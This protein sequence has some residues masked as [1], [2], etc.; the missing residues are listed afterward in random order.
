MP[1]RRRKKNPLTETLERLVYVIKRGPAYEIGDQN[2]TRQDYD[3]VQRKVPTAVDPVS[4]AKWFED[5][6]RDVRHMP[7][8]GI[9]YDEAYPKYPGDVGREVFTR[10]KRWIDIASLLVQAAKVLVVRTEDNEFTEKER[11]QL[12]KLGLVD[13]QIHELELGTLFSVSEIK[14][15]LRKGFSVEEILDL[16]ELGEDVDVELASKL[17]EMGFETKWLIQLM[18]KYFR[19]NV[20]VLRM[21]LDQGYDTPVKLKEYVEKVFGSDK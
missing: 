11:E 16:W 18:D 4:Q 6:Y 13:D 17:K 14:S 19:R 8:S 20:E 7:F 3:M 15:F 10:S 21:L 2:P 5:R 12:S 1:V 9:Y